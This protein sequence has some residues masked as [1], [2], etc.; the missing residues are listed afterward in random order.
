M[1][2]PGT[3]VKNARGKNSFMEKEEFGPTY[4]GLEVPV[5][6]PRGDMGS[7]IVYRGWSLGERLKV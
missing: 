2:I 3:E 6:Y 7:A 4:V 1:V 5:D